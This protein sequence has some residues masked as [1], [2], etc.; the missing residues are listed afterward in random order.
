MNITVY[1]GANEGKDPSL[2][3]AVRELGTWIGESG[4]RL[5]YGGSK[6]G[7]MGELAES[8]LQAGG[9]VIGVEPQFFIDMEYQYDEITELIVTKDMTERKMK[10][11][12][13]GDVFIAF[14][15]G[16]GTLE[17][18]AEVMSKVSLKHLTAPC[19]LYNLN[20]YYDGLQTLL[21]HMTEMGLSS[22]ERQEGIYFAKD[23]SEIREI[24]K[25][26]RSNVT[27][28]PPENTQGVG[29]HLG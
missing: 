21:R 29:N 27:I 17:E 2:K 19:I 5:I 15:G 3:T 24:I 8:V 12:E 28:A 11:I 18:I 26:Q 4:S 16:T 20:D 14:P 1:L 23:L 10:M 22:P 25:N 9:E 13:L 7:L 6:S